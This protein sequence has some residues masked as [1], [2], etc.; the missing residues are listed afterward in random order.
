MPASLRSRRFRPFIDVL[1]RRDVPSGFD[2]S[3]MDAVIVS[4]DPSSSVPTTPAEIGPMDAVLL[5]DR[6]KNG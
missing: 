2:I 6:P 3:P 5:T 4:M 1:D